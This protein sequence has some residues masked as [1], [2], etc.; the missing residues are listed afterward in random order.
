M[1]YPCYV[2]VRALEQRYNWLSVVRKDDL[3]EVLAG[4]KTAEFTARHIEPL[5]TMQFGCL[6]NHLLALGEKEEKNFKLF[7]PAEKIRI[8][9]QLLENNVH[10]RYLVIGMI[11]GLFTQQELNYFTEHRIELCKQMIRVLT[12]KLRQESHLLF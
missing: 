6:V 10:E 11:A 4:S 8:I 9:K 7:K 1:T 12:Q 3:N 5:V 2:I